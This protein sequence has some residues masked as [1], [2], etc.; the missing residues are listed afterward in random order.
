[1]SNP[2]D[3][4]EASIAELRRAIRDASAA[5][6]A[7]R[8]AELR[9]QLRRTERAWD[10]L[11]DTE[12]PPDLPAAHSMG[13][14]PIVREQLSLPARE[15]AYRVLMLLRAPA[16]PKLIAS[17]HGAFF[18]EELATSKLSS[19][20]RDEERSYRA[21][22]GNRPYYL[23]PAL[24]HDLL[25]PARGLVTISTWP[26]EQRVV[27]PLSPRVDF[28][29]GA[30][31]IANAVQAA[32]SS[33]VGPTPAA[34]R[35]LWRFAANIPDAMAASS[36]VYGGKLDPT[37]VVDAARAELEIHESADRVTR[38]QS[39]R[40]A[41]KQLGAEQQLFGAPITQLRRTQPGS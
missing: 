12:P 33:D 31:A 14:E 32:Q 6:N 22:P 30:I 21:S 26:L 18:P 40:R 10:A 41:R 25:A 29:N 16:A 20:R 2:L 36:G 17:V 37:R 13:A 35:L 9:A 15:Q 24:T 5:G 11:V 28:L 23:C 1:M 34:M 4:L 38:A 19:L 8:A 39:A 27:G 7:E 3:T